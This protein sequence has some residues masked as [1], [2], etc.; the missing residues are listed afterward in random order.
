M[1]EAASEAAASHF[2][3]MRN[4]NRVYLEFYRANARLIAVLEQMSTI[5]DECARVRLGLRDWFVGRNERHIR[6]LQAEGLADPR[7][8][9]FSTGQALVS[10]VERMS[11]NWFVLGLT[12]PPD[13]ADRLSLVWARA[14]GM[15][16][17][18]V[19]R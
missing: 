17:Q 1:R 12:S 19:R 10:M 16:V 2:V 18:G 9:P 13:A 15:P 14:V 11:F 6:T 8:D 3:R 5:D 4:A 7:L